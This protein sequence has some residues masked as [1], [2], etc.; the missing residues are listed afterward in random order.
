MSL[1]KNLSIFFKEREDGNIKTLKNP[2]N[3]LIKG[4]SFLVLDNWMMIA[5]M[6]MKKKIRNK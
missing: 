3:L 2:R 5:V 6:L 4:F 1:K